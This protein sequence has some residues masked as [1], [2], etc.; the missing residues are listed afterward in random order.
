MVYIPVIGAI[1]ATV[2]CQQPSSA[3]D[4]LN[5]NSVDQSSQVAET[6]SVMGDLQITCH[7]MIGGE[8]SRSV[9]TY[10]LKGSM[11]YKI[12]PKGNPVL[13][14]EEDAIIQI[15]MTEDDEGPEKSLATHTKSDG[16]VIRTVFWQRPGRDK[17]VA[18]TEVYDFS[19]Q[20]VID[21]ET[22]EDSCHHDAPTAH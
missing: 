10:L 2:A 22:G 8:P 9:T 14:S 6:K 20:Q 15:S 12:S 4:K 19:N 7:E 1:L 3:T 13:I 5:G 17:R 11:L 16:K 21:S 18:F